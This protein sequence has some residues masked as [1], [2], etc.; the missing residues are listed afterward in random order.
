VISAWSHGAHWVAVAYD[1]DYHYLLNSLALA[2]G[3]AP[4]H[5]DHPGTT[6]QELG[7]AVLLVRHGLHPGGVSLRDQVLRDPESAIAAISVTL[8][9]LHALTLFLFGLRAARF[10]GCITCAAFAQLATL[11]SFIGPMSLWRL[12]PEPLLM[13]LTLLLACATLRAL[14]RPDDRSPRF[15][16]TAGITVGLGI[17]T[18]ATFAPLALVPLW[19]AARSSRTRTLAA[20]VLCAGVTLLLA[21]APIHEHWER[22]LVWFHGLAVNDGIYGKPAGHRFLDPS[23]YPLDLAR[24]IG[25][26]PFAFV[27]AAAGAAAFAR[28]RFAGLHRSLD[29][30]SLAA[31]RALAFTAAAILVQYVLV[32]KHPGDRYLVPALALT[33]LL[34]PLAYRIAGG[35]C[36][37][38]RRPTRC[39]AAGIAIAA[40]SLAVVFTY[41]LMAARADAQARIALHERALQL[42]AEGNT[43][44][45]AYASS[46]PVF[47]L[48]FADWWTLDPRAHRNGLFGATLRE[49]Y[50]RQWNYNIWGHTW[51]VG[52][53]QVH[54][55]LAA[56]AAAAG[57]L[58]LQ[59]PRD[60]LPDEFDYTELARAGEEGLYRARPR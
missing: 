16:I 27:A 33:G 7:A 37:P 23:R 55:R 54:P 42:V 38:P 43:L 57:T 6:L 22:V 40:A 10:T 13:S 11:L 44:A 58:Y 60:S 9:S 45:C 17:A 39:T 53:G 34:V 26:E 47:A 12:S 35:G 29:A 2:E 41:R 24:M 46:S 8:R 18:K 52:A 15:A 30:A 14:A 19:A 51:S 48:T 21:L 28:T 1:P 50:P 31:L 49:M 25:Q 56:E 36:A 5:T 4:F 59:S 20:Y 3:V 32:A